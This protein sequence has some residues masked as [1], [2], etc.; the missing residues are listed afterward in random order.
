MKR[1]RRLAS[2]ST[3]LLVLLALA[4]P[5]EAAWVKVYNSQEDEDV[6]GS[7]TDDLSPWGEIVGQGITSWYFIAAPPDAT[8]D[9]LSVYVSG[10]TGVPAWSGWGWQYRIKIGR[11]A[12]SAIS[13][14]PDSQVSGGYTTVHDGWD[15]AED[16]TG[17]P[18]WRDIDLQAPYTMSSAEK[19]IIK[20]Q[21]V[22]G[23]GGD[24]DDD[25]YWLSTGDYITHNAYADN[26]GGSVSTSA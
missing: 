13:T 11:T 22:S 5:G 24:P 21:Y 7:T 18:L 26:S 2:V 25:N 1:L 10:A 12:V 3:G 14:T 17:W 8:I 16:L 6:Q 19:Y 4:C 20:F 15:P 9:R 23:G